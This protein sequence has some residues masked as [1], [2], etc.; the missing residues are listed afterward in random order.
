MAIE[1][2]RTQLGRVLRFL[3]FLTLISILAPRRAQAYVDPSTGSI[4]IQVLIA[5]ALGAAF[6]AKQ[7]WKRLATAARELRERVT[8]R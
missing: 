2:R 5:G 8:R 6:T 4:V 1:V 3:G 7:W